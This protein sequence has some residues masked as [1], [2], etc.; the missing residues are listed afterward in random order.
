MMPS[1]PGTIPGYI[2]RFRPALYRTLLAC[3][4]HL[5]FNVMNAATGADKHKDYRMIGH[6]KY[7][8]ANVCSSVK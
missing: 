7:R 2:H 3:Q 5:Q 8:T 6:Q 1:D 4:K